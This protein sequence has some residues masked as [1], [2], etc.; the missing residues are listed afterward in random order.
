[1][2]PSANNVINSISDNQMIML[3]PTPIKAITTSDLCHDLGYD[4]IT[5][6]TSNATN[7]PVLENLFFDHLLYQL[8]DL[9]PDQTHDQSNNQLLDQLYKATI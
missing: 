7:N 4:L 1:M 2:I 8:R 6:N 3:T 9:M 5:S